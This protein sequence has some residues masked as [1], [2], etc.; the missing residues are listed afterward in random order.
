M[1]PFE[2]YTEERSVRKASIDVELARSLIKDMNERINENFKENVNKKP[3]TIFENIY[4]ALRDFCDAILAL[5]GYKSYSHEASISYLLK[6][7]FDVE[8]VNKIDSFRYKRNGS[9]YYGKSIIPS[10]AKEIKEFYLQV[11]PKID[12]LIKDNKLR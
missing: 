11:Q 5:E 10:E 4:D 9:K 2:F 7:G 3:K 1:K 6:K 8:T 12:K